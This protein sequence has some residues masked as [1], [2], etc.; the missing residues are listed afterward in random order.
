MTMAGTC[1]TSGGLDDA[2][3]TRTRTDETVAAVADLIATR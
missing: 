3:P 1:T 2:E